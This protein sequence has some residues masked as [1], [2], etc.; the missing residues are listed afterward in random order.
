MLKKI[1]LPAAFVIA[2][3]GVL[4]NKV[5]NKLPLIGD[6][7]PSFNAR[8]T[9]GWINFPLA[10][11]GSWVIFFS[12]PADFTPVCTTEFMTFES[13][14]EE[15]EKL[16]TI[17]LSLSVDS[18][19]SH[20]A[21]IKD[22][23][24]KIDYNGMSDI[25]INFPV[26]DDIEGKVAK[27]YGMIQPNADDTKAVRA[28]FIIDPESIIRAILY[29]PQTTGRN[30]DEIKRLLVALQTSDR[31][32][33]ATPANWEAGSEVIIPAPAN[34]QEAIERLENMDNINCYDWFLCF[35]DL[36]KSKI[37]ETLIASSEEHSQCS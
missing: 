36:P 2:A 34:K 8:S 21:W 35:K 27:K 6:R 31:F 13:M 15:F 22:I 37:N 28:V 5:K 24:E 23:K 17:L 25:D 11:R 16:N 33:V 32:K 26:I 12:H 10:Y 7:A 20:L 30:I 14:Q 18:V 29:Y 4:K 3:Y 9:Q 19:K 1:L